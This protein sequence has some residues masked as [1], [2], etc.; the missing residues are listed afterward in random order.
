MSHMPSTPPTTA[1]GTPRYLAI[2]TELGQAILSGQLAP[3]EKLAPHRVMAK[4]L[5]VTT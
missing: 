4:R 3:G 5:G 2:A 1:G